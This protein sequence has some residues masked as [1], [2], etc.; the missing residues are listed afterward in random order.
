MAF[1]PLTVLLV[2]APAI[3]SAEDAGKR[4]EDAFGE[5]SPA[6]VEAGG[7]ARPVP[8]SIAPPLPRP[9]PPQ[10][11]LLPSPT[12]VAASDAQADR[13]LAIVAPLQE[14]M[15]AC[16]SLGAYR[17]GTFAIA[18]PGTV[19]GKTTLGEDTLLI[20][21]ALEETGLV[22]I[23]PAPPSPP[24]ASGGENT[25]AQQA[26][27]PGAATDAK[28]VSIGPTELAKSKGLVRTP[29]CGSPSRRSPRSR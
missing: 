11:A 20:Y 5:T 17:L 2:L 6:A 1:R 19:A 25:P 28:S 13:A 8:Q 21:Q 24:P 26:P 9:R 18:K 7:E 14:R 3:A 12:A 27:G 22:T 29:C 23:A 15:T 4:F 10:P 16:C